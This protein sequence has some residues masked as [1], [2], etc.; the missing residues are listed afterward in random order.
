MTTL[1]GT[2]PSQPRRWLRVI[3]LIV[4][5]LE[6]VRGLQKLNYLF[7]EAAEIMDAAGMT[8]PERIGLA[9]TPLLAL[10]GF[11]FAW[12]RELPRAIM[13]LAAIA[14]VTWLAYLPTVYASGAELAMDGA[15]A[16]L[17]V[18]TAVLP[19]LALAAIAMAWQGE[20]LGLA[21]LLAAVPAILALA[22]SVAFMI[23]MSSFG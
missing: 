12:R 8:L 22:A 7:G 13:M 16:I 6:F 4:T 21:T 20:R 18:E 11:V 23:G 15:T 17:L 1:T 3:L 9:C 10:G 19:L 14:I 5:A 2:A